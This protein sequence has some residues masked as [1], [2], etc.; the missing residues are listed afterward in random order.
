[1]VREE[2]KFY[3][4]KNSRFPQNR[5]VWALETGLKTDICITYATRKKLERLWEG[6]RV[7]AASF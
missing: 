6:A 3:K 4:Y 7:T 2:E 5:S 1:M